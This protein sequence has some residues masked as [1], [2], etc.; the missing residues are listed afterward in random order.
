MN[1]LK[2]HELLASCSQTVNCS[3]LHNFL[4]QKCIFFDP[5]ICISVGN[6]SRGIKGVSVL[7]PYLWVL[8]HNTVSH[9]PHSPNWEKEDVTDGALSG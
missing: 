2:S 4:L 9:L 8:Q 7:I 5:Q 3:I 1:Q 6:V